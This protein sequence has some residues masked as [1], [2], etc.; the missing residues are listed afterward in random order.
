MTSSPAHVLFRSPL[1]EIGEFRCGPEHPRWEELNDIGERPHVVFPGTS[2]VIQHVGR[3]PVLVNRNHV[4]FYN[5]HDGYYRRLHDA[6]GDHCV[7]VALA[8][9]LFA[10][11]VGADRVDFTHAPG[12]PHAFLG[13]WTVTRRLRAGDRDGLYVEESVLEAVRHSVKVALEHHGVQSERRRTTR[14]RH[15]EL[16]EAA[17]AV[18]TE[19]ACARISLGDVAGR[20]HTSEFH[21]ARLFRAHTG[22]TLH[23]YRNQLRLR[24]ALERIHD[25]DDLTALAHELGFSSHSHFT[26]AFRGLFGAPPAE[27]RALGAS[28]REPSRVPQAGPAGRS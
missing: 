21:L 11:L 12:T 24:L 15:R 25:E 5:S 3:E 19:S 17:K 22:F 4:T 28:L 8:P 27:V 13:Q 20:L 16:V 6:C 9:R 1:L 7:Y 26:D 2:V 10:Q 23:G 18:L 14:E